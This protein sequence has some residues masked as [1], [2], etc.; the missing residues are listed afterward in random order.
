[1]VSTHRSFPLPLYNRLPYHAPDATF[2]TRITMKQYS[3][4]DDRQHSHLIVLRATP[5][6]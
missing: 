2:Y 5:Y 1:M 4:V 3:C 6:L